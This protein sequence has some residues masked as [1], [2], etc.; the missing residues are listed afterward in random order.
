MATIHYDT[1][2]KDGERYV[3]VADVKAVCDDIKEKSKEREQNYLDLLEHWQEAYVK[4]KSSKEAH[5]KTIVA[6]K[7]KLKETEMQ[8]EESYEALK[9]K[10][11]DPP[12]ESESEEENEEAV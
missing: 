3:K 8:W 5:I 6:L 4:E 2:V 11:N 9:A 1:W 12:T 7:A 10:Y